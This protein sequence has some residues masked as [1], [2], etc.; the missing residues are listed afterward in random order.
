MDTDASRIDA[1]Y[2]PRAGFWRR[3]LATVIDTIV[4]MVPFQA[5]AAAL[6]AIT[7]GMIQMNSGFYR[8]CAP[9][10]AIPPLLEPA[11]PHDSNFVNVCR[12][13]FFGATTGALLI[14]GRSTRE[15]N[16]TTNVTVSYMLD[17][18]GNPIPGRSING[19]FELAFL[20]YLV[21]MVWKTGTTVGARILKIRVIDTADP[22]QSGVPLRKAIVRYLAL[23]IG[24][25]PMFAV[26]MFQRVFVG[27]SADAMFTAAFF[28]W[29]MYAGGL[30][31]VWAIVLFFQIVLKKDP[32]YDR[33]AGTAAIRR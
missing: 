17:R 1:T 31:A 24:Y 14:V 9:V 22:E 8:F 4:V 19:I 28:R 12:T 6:F 3:S 13:S 27:S 29:F 10:E 33:L 18:N 30:A 2:L 32:V 26:L 20:V 16:T 15:G 5:L 23:C 21:G 25:V 11:P 7:A